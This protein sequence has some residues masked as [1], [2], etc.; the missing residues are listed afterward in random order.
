MFLRE[1]F[2]LFLCVLCFRTSPTHKTICQ[3]SRIMQIT[4]A[5]ISVLMICYVSVEIYSSFPQTMPHLIS[6]QAWKVNKAAVIHIQE[7]SQRNE[8]TSSRSHN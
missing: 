6:Q 2:F 3:F 1:F 7:T 8:V 5:N 4:K